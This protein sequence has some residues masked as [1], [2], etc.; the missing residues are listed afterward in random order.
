MK[1]V[2][3]G[4]LSNTIESIHFELQWNFV[5]KIRG[6]EMTKVESGN[7]NNMPWQSFD[8]GIARK[9]LAMD[10]KY[11]NIA[12]NKIDNNQVFEAH[13]HK[14][15]EQILMIL[16][17]ECVVYIEDTPHEMTAG[18]WI[19]VPEGV[20]HSMEVSDSP[21]PLINMDVFSP[22]REEYNEAYKEFIDGQ[23]S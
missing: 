6:T 7:W 22:I 14:D 15:Q 11:A 1:K 13:S 10:A 19:A 12:I 8:E 4:S 5:Y 18:S 16:Q 20:E 23:S 17:G 3:L 2:I 21:E 9:M